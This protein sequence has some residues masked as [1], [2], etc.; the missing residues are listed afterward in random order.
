MRTPVHW[1]TLKSKM[2]RQPRRQQARLYLTGRGL[3]VESPTSTP[4]RAIAPSK[5]RWHGVS[6][7]PLRLFRLRSTSAF[8]SPR[9][10]SL[11]Q[12]PSQPEVLTDEH[13]LLVPQ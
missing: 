7:R 1:Q 5:G 12:K 2:D 8:N 4:E 9:E 3:E 13:L 11:Y 6:S 10:I